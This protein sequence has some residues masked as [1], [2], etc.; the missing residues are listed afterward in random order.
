M[1]HFVIL[2]VSDGTPD[3]MTMLVSDWTLCDNVGE[4]WNTVILS[5]SDGTLWYCW[6]V[7]D[8]TPDLMIMLLSDGTFC[9]T[10]GEWQWWNTLWYYWWVMEHFVILSV[11]DGTLCDTVAGSEECMQSV[12]Y[13]APVLS[14]SVPPSWTLVVISSCITLITGAWTPRIQ[15]ANEWLQIDL[16][17]QY[18]ITKLHTQGRRGSDEYVMEFFL[19]FSDDG[20]TW[21]RYTNRYGIAEVISAGFGFMF[22]SVYFLF[23]CFVV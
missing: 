13:S 16:G 22:E 15:N 7:S 5:V 17:K 6:P 9:D 21:K 3:L 2:L 12:A 8:G 1:E 20:T 23:S 10:V 11:S 14:E 19:E 18:I 4:W